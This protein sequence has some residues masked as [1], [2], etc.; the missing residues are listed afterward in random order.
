[1][2]SGH[3]GLQASKS[4]SLMTSAYAPQAAVPGTCNLF[5]IQPSVLP[6][7]SATPLWLGSMRQVSEDFCGYS[8]LSHLPPSQKSRQPNEICYKNMAD[9]FSEELISKF[10]EAFSTSD[11]DGDGKITAKK[12]GTVMRLLARSLTDAELEDMVNEANEDD[13]AVADFPEFDAWMTRKV[14]CT[15]SQEKS[16]N[17]FKAL[18]KD[19]NGLISM[20]ELRRI[21]TYLGEELTDEEATEMV[22]ETDVAGEAQISYDEFVKMMSSK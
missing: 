9:Q 16:R 18:D 4:V 11:Q 13:E 6:R 14:H 10:E 19:E 3:Y 8:L 2:D 1:M 5:R 20:A 17:A 21:M 22:R 12:L 15:D 7:S